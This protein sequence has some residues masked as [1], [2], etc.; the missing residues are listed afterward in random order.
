[1]LIVSLVFQYRDLSRLHRRLYRGPI[2]IVVSQGDVLYISDVE[3]ACTQEPFHTTEDAA[4]TDDATAIENQSVDAPNSEVDQSETTI[5]TVTDGTI[6]SSSASVVSEPSPNVNFIPSGSSSDS[7][8]DKCCSSAQRSEAAMVRKVEEQ[9]N[10]LLRLRAVYRNHRPSSS[11]PSVGRSS[12]SV[13]QLPSSSSDSGVHALSSA[14][15][16]QNSSPED[17]FFDPLLRPPPQHSQPWKCALVVCVPLRLGEHSI[18]STYI[19]VLTTAMIFP[20][21]F[22][23]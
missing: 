3:K 15:G 20:R 5:A 22:V 16:P 1:M 4:A 21:Q 6:H 18:E 7:V 8:D 9:I 19:E 2:E 14:N 11:Q 17:E 10:S 13:Q 12:I 23:Y